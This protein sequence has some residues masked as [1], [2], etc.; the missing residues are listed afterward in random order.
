MKPILPLA[1]SA[2]LIQQVFA[3]VPYSQ[4]ILAPESRTIFP[5]QIHQ[6]NGSI[7][8]SKSLIGGPNGTAT[9]NGV[10]SVTFD[11]TKN[12]GG[13]VSLTVGKSSS[14]DAF[15]GLTYTESSLWIN[16]QGSDAT[17]DAG[18]DEVI[19]LPVG[20]GAGTYTVERKYDRGSFRY[21]SVVSNS[22]AT[23]EVTGVSV[24]YT[25]APAQDLRDYSGY[26]HSNDELLNR[27][28]Y[29]GK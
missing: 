22:S 11:Y 9:F 28:W 4:Y 15:L 19:W 23:I 16:G 6:V 14:S 21:L 8:H 3:E 24:Y 25:A 13:V 17:A 1:V 27:I 12:I 20:E 7:T 2:S 18:L 26:F 10:S 5:P 29:A